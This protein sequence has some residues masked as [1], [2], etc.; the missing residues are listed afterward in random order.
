MRGMKDHLLGHRTAVVFA[1]SGA[2]GAYHAGVLK[3]LDEAGVRIDLLVGSGVGVLAAAFGAAGSGSALYGEKG[4]WREISARRVFRL[5]SGFRFLRSLGLVALSAFLVPALLALLLG[6]LLPAFLAVD[7]ARPGFMATLTQALVALAPG[8][9]LFFIFALAAPTFLGFLFLLFRGAGALKSS[10][11]RFGE[12]L[13]SAFDLSGIEREVARRL[14]EVARGP[15]LNDPPPDNSEIGRQYSALIAENAGQPGFRGL[16]LRAANL[17]A[18]KPLVLKLVAD[19]RSAAGRGSETDGLVDLK[20][21][22]AAPLLYDVVATAFAATPFASPRRV[23]LPKQGAFGGEV[24]RIVE[25][26]ALVG[27][28]LGEAIA[29]GANQIVFVTATAREPGPLPERRGLKALAAAFLALQ[30][31]NA[32]E[33]DLS[34][35][36]RINRIVETVGHQKSTGE[37]EWQDPLT[38]RRFRSVP[39][40]VVRPRRP[41]LRPLDLDGAVDPSNEVETSLLDWLD[42]GHRDAHRCFLEAALG[43]DRIRD[44]GPRPATAGLSL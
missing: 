16:V 2:S 32:I 6:L 40:H 8:L 11:R 36:E 35:T 28:G 23:R 24:H 34:Q 19:D 14:W 5:R 17:D 9:R 29:L 21:A 7:F 20:E 1:G 22:A 12:T 4:L 33:S 15:A 41:L 42:E 13:E 39:I 31:R 37:R 10:K 25:S 44:E 18:R 43:E 26:S 30:E 3:A 38:G 27:S